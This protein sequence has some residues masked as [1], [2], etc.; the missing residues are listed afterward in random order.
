VEAILDQSLRIEGVHY[1]FDFNRVWSAIRV[2]YGDFLLKMESL[3]KTITYEFEKE[4]QM[5][6]RRWACSLLKSGLCGPD[7]L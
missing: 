1:T 5:K 4:R 6:F 7:V 2:R 3:S